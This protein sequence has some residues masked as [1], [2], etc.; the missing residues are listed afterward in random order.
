MPGIIDSNTKSKEI[1]N[2]SVHPLKNLTWTIIIPMGTIVE[3]YADISPDQALLWGLKFQPHPG[4]TWVL[5]CP[6]IFRASKATLGREAWCVDWGGNGAYFL[7]ISNQVQ[8]VSQ[9]CFKFH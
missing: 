1:T 4:T 8:N 7:M 3:S 6:P 2:Q 9:A 5:H